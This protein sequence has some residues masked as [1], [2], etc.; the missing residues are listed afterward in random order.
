MLSREDVRSSGARP[1]HLLVLVAP[2][3]LAALRSLGPSW[4][5]H[6]ANAEDAVRQLQPGGFTICLV[7]LSL[8]GAG[9]VIQQVRR[10]CP[11][12]PVVVIGRAGGEAAVADALRQGVAGFVPATALRVLL[13][14]VLEQAIQPRLVGSE[15]PGELIMDE[16]R[17][18]AL[19]LRHEINN[20]LTGI[21]G[22]AEFALTAPDLSPVLE[23][24]LR[25]IVKLAEHIRDLLRQLE[26]FPRQSPPPAVL[27]AV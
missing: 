24:R 18:L 14:P 17:L 9:A 13:G 12:L 8:K 1:R 25:N 20:P 6:R 10:K 23:R 22:N 26:D 5:V 11:Q 7:D 27:S 19:A 16:L 4:C 15:G 21:L 2:R 3:H